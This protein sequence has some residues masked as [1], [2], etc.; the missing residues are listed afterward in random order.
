MTRFGG[1]HAPDPR[2]RVP[3]RPADVTQEAIHASR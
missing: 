2:A 3:R 1:N